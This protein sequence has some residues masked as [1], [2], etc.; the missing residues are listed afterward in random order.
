MQNWSPGTRAISAGR[1][2]TAEVAGRSFPVFG[3]YG[4][5]LVTSPG[6]LA[7]A[8]TGLAAE[9]AAIDAAC[10]RFRA[11]SEISLVNRAG[12]RV[13]EVSDLF[14]TALRTA[15]TAAALTDGDVDPT[16]GGS[17]VNLGYDRDFA[18]VRADTTA[19][20]RAAEPAPGW[21][22]VELDIR[23]RTVRIPAGALLDLGATAKALA[24]DRAA[25]RIAAAV[26]C[27]V[28]V[29][30]GGDLA[31]AGQPPA[32]GWRIEV[33]DELPADQDGGGPAGPGRRAPGQKVSIS[34]GGLATSCTATRG[35]RR[36]G[37]RLHHIVVPGTGRPAGGC[38]RT[39]SVAAASCVGANT[40]STA[41]IIRG[42]RAAGW[43]ERLGLPARLVRFDGTVV[44][45]GG[46]PADGRLEGV[47]DREIPDRTP[48]RTP[49][50]GAE[51]TPERR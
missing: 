9:T 2:A 20:T 24:A 50:G 41:A 49:D 37:E 22:Q 26:G 47:P 4:S 25:A 30:L 27:G 23:R 21:Q 28:L 31:V 44:T 29:N 45:T 7:A 3:T 33:T 32:G 42:H 34:A 18:Q 15:L 11:D 19:L 36:G 14:A 43:L 38:W 6:A 40:A 35:W 12:G 5:V 46:W 1:P 48:H 16:C 39:V 10:S 13:V 51:L 17:L 8:C